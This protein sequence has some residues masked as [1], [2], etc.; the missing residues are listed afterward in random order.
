[1]STALIDAARAGALAVNV[2][3]DVWHGVLLI[4]WYCT[5]D[6]FV[7]AV[8]VVGWYVWLGIGHCSCTTLH[9]HPT[10]N[11]NHSSNKMIVLLGDGGSEPTEGRGA[12]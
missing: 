2:I 4:G 11:N 12:S 7:V 6:V 3:N 9:H 8:V 5:G 10:N 1:M